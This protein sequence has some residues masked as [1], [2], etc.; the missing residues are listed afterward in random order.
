MLPRHCIRRRGA[1]R[2]LQ[3]LRQGVAA[4]EPVGS[5]DLET[6]WAI[7]Q[8]YPD[9]DFSLVDRTSFA[10]MLRLGIRRVATPDNHFAVYR[11]GPHQRNA[12]EIVRRAV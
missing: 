5:A 1:E 2:L 9:Q 10:V 6:A 3:A 12:F 11:Y 4:V 8:A 7:G